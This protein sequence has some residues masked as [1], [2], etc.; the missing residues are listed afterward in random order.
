MV[1]PQHTRPAWYSAEDDTA[2]NKVKAAF[3]RDWKQT[4]HDF[5]GSSPDLNQDVADTVK[6]AAGKE[7]IPPPGQ[8]NFEDYEPALRY[9]YGARRYYGKQYPTWDSRLEQTL[10]KDWKSP[11]DWTRYGKAV[12]E[13]YEFNPKP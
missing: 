7:H 4:K 12:R 3:R 2:W 8:P 9:G 1:A 6:Q 13:G 11:A 5:G 10:Q